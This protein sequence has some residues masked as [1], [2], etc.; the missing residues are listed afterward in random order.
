MLPCPVDRDAVDILL[1]VCMY[2]SHQLMSV[3]QLSLGLHDRLRWQGETWAYAHAKQAKTL[4]KSAQ[5]QHCHVTAYPMTS[6]GQNLSQM[7][8]SWC[9]SKEF[10]QVRSTLM[11][12]SAC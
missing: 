8:L 9:T 3:L 7:N 6:T 11:L 4:V 12:T 10:A 1:L 5:L 2:V